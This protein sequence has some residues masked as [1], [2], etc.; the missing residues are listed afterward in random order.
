VSCLSQV[1]RL[2]VLHGG[3]PLSC[4]QIQLVGPGLAQAH[5]THAQPGSEPSHAGCGGKCTFCNHRLNKARSKAILDGVDLKTVTYTPACV[6]ACPTKAIHF[7]N[8][9]DPESAVAKL[10]KDPRAFRILANS[11]RSRK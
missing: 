10:A 11:I 1:H 8:L 9:L 2:P 5:G 6:E 4:A 7:G 3:M